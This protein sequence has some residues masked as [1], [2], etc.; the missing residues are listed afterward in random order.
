VTVTVADS[1]AGGFQDVIVV[2]Q[3]PIGFSQVLTSPPYQFSIL[4]PPDI[5]PRRYAV[6]ADGVIAPGQGAT[7][8]PIILAVERADAPTSIYVEP[9]VLDFDLTGDDC[10]LR[11]V[12]RYADGSQTDIT[13]SLYTTYA[14]NDPSVATVN[15]TG[16]VTAVAPGTTRIVINGSYSVQVTVQPPLTALP[17]QKGLHP[18]QTQQFYAL[19]MDPSM[20]GVVWSSSPV[21]VGNI[22]PAGLYTAPSSIPSLQF[23]TI[24]ATSGAQT[25]SATIT[26]YPPISVGMSPGAVALGPSQTQQFSASVQ[27]ASY[28]GLI[29]S[30]V[31]PGTGSITATGVYT[32]PATVA[33]QQNVTVIATSV[34]DGTKSASANVTLNPPP[35][36][37]ASI[38]PASGAQGATVSVTLNGS[39][40][41]PG[42]S[43]SVTNPAVSVTNVNV[44]S[45]T[46]ITATFTIGTAA[47][48]GAANV[49]VTTSSGTSGP[50]VFTV[51]PPPPALTSISPSTGARGTA[52][53]LTLNGTNFVSGAAVGVDNSGITVSAV[54]VLSTSRITATFT[55]SP[56]AA[57]GS[58]NVTVT[59][60]GGVSGTAIFTV[61]ATPVLTSISPAN[62][63]RGSSV[64]VTVTGVNLVSGATV[65][66]MDSTIT[67]TDVTV[68]SPRPY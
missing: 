35:P 23:V 17:A 4:I 65:A 62:G 32:A 61:T 16:V 13:E 19:A 20:P 50:A 43:V 44:V 7:S 49:T 45:G 14:S 64:P 37:L 67:V 63:L 6:T 57:L 18:S 3:N 47:A 48:V 30:T 10:S 24:V 42:A 39:N 9:S 5:S 21:G 28:T 34:A 36:S 31:P 68:V 27:N 12:G 52:V 58:A 11:V 40:F 46:Q 1:P 60:V 25:T 59:T 51:N 41:I 56:S 2:G 38:S 66:T 26:L 53:S 33:T 29:W 54:A 8:E 15:S 22:T 55:I